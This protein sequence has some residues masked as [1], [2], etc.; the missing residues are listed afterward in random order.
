MRSE[1]SLRNK[2]PMIIAFSITNCLQPQIPMI[3]KAS[4]I[5][6]GKVVWSHFQIEYGVPQQTLI[7]LSELGSADKKTKTKCSYCTAFFLPENLSHILA[8]CLAEIEKVWGTELSYCS[9]I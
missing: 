3:A 6:H 7:N 4:K 9:N 5:I 1:S 8:Y 2:L